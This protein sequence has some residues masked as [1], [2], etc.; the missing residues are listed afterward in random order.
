MHINN[1]VVDVRQYDH[2]S[3]IVEVEGKVN[4]NFI[5]ILIDLVAILSYVTP[6]L[7]DSNKFKKVKH[8]KSWLLQI[9]IGT[10]RKVT[11]FI[12][13]CE[14]NLDGQNTNSNLNILPLGS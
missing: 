6:G 14:L 2:Q 1:V 4:N 5:S 13:N 11:H 8:T 12:S 7:L 10:K 3:T 9:A